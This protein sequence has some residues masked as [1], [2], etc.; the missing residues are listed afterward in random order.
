MLIVNQID[1]HIIIMLVF[2]SILIIVAVIT[3]HARHFETSFKFSL[4]GRNDGWMFIDKMTFA[5]GK[6]QIT[7]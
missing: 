1:S 7:F 2:K 3:A 5:P 6:A 4:F